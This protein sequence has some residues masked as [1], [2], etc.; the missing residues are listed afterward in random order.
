GFSITDLARCDESAD[1]GATDVCCRQVLHSG[2]SIAECI[3][4]LKGGATPCDWGE[5]CVEGSVCRHPGTTC[6]DGR[7]LKVAKIDCGGA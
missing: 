1:C 2:S 7:C 6:I 4:P 3:P 5:V